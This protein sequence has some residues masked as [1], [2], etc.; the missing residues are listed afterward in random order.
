[1]WN[2]LLISTALFIYLIAAGC[3]LVSSTSASASRQ[4]ETTYVAPISPPAHMTGLPLCGCGMQI[5]RVDWIDRY[6]KSIDEVANIGG[7]TVLLVVDAR[8]EN[9]TSSKIYLDMRMTPD[10]GSAGGAH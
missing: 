8:M 3:A 1:M 4:E 9:G 6:E 5:Q 7:D 10:A 2:K